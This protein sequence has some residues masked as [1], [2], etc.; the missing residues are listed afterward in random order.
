MLDLRVF[1]R[2][3]HEIKMKEALGW[4]FFW[5]SL[6]LIFCAGVYAFRGPGMAMKFLAGYLIEESLSVDNLFVFLVIFN[7]FR[8]P[9][10]Y[11][12]RVLFWGIVGALIMRGI[13][14]IAG[15]A[16]IH[17]FHWIIY[18][19]GVFLIYTAVKL[20][21]GKDEEVQPEKNIFLKILRRLMPVT[22]HYE[23]EKFFVKKDGHFF[24]TPLVAV[25][26][27]IET[28]DVLF[29]V[30][31]VPAVLSISTDPFI[32]YT[33]NIFAIL[34]LRAL[35]F[36]LAGLMKLFKYLHYGLGVIL[37]FVGIKMILS[38]WFHIPIGIA[39]GFIAGVL[40]L[41]ILASYWSMKNEGKDRLPNLGL[42]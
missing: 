25:L 11:Q 31:S 28:T 42:L 24:A 39:L 18:V 8:V 30:D 34:G 4:S 6:A 19:F 14:I 23:G 26:L 35:F 36:A 13:F 15:V 29:A 40:A 12:H 20:I 1:H 2:T 3:A 21:T 22:D 9:A 38:R 7:Y 37:G 16:L 5:I 32:V 27:V 10:R 33:S 41:C 17:R